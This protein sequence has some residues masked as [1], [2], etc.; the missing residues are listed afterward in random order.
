MRIILLIIDPQE[1]FHPPTG[2]LAVPG[3]DEDAVRISNFLLEKL[4]AID[5]V[6][7][8]MDSHHRTHIAHS[9]SWVDENGK[10]PPPFTLISSEDV[11][12]NVWRPSNSD[13]LNEYKDYTTELEAK[14]RF[15]LCIWPEHCLI[16][17]PGHSV[18]QPI[19]GSLHEWEGSRMKSVTYV[20]KGTNCL[21]E[22][23]SAIGAEVPVESDPT[24]KPNLNLLRFLNGADKVIVQNIS[25]LV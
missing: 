1:D 18:V 10:N 9:I 24:T 14:G 19:N 3:A 6:V 5:D 16:G 4:T 12:G 13:L 7:V 25:L 17:T 2:S 23:Y 20:L 22:M 8:T 15:K 11:R 21:T